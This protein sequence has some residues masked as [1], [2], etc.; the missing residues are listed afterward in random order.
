MA[1]QPY[2]ALAVRHEGDCRNKKASLLS[3]M[4]PFEQASK[5]AFPKKYTNKRLQRPAKPH[6]RVCHGL[7]FAPTHDVSTTTTLELFKSKLEHASTVA[8]N[9]Y[10][11]VCQ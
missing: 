2:S 9:L 3:S 10:F 5:S 11:L 8:S 7:P 1:R 4:V 6:Q